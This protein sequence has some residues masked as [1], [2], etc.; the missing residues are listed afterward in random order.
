MTAAAEFGSLVYE[1]R[2]DA[3]LTQQQLADMIG[4]TQAAVSRWERGICLPN[5]Y[6]VRMLCESAP[7]FASEWTEIW[8]RG[9]REIL[10]YPKKAPDK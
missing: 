6:A 5:H 4:V 7:G 8:Q 3:Y 2:E 9:R 10:G 1:F